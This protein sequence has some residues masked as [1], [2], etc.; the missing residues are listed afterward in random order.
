MGRKGVWNSFPS[1]HWEK[2]K[3]TKRSSRKEDV[4]QTQ[5]ASKLLICSLCSAPSSSDCSSSPLA[6]V[7]PT[8]SISPFLTHQCIVI[9]SFLFTSLKI[10]SSKYIHSTKLIFFKGLWFHLQIYTHVWSPNKNKISTS[11]I[12]VYVRWCRYQHCKGSFDISVWIRRCKYIK[13]KR[14][15]DTLSICDK[16]RNILIYF[17]SI[18]RNEISYV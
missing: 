15:I 13:I 1:L 10:V 8:L 16:K 11:R 9:L 4:W 5:F 3:N 17:K 18:I 7:S 14:M 12:E 6:V 2:A